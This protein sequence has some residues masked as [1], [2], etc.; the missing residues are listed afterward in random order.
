MNITFS[1]TEMIILDLM[2]HLRYLKTSE[3]AAEQIQDYSLSPREIVRRGVYTEY[4]VSKYMNVF[5]DLNCDYRKFGADL[6][7]NLGSAIDVKSTTHKG[8]PLNAKSNATKKPGDIFICTEINDNDVVTIVGFIDRESF[9]KQENIKQGKYKG[10]Y[11][12]VPQHVLKK[13][14]GFQY[15]QTL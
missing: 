3:N 15:P 5:F 7:S 9:L 14:R 6:I 10:F 4:A 12:S 2:A 11:Y 8:G 13:F 1:N